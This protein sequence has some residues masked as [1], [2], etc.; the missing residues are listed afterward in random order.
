[1]TSFIILYTVFVL[2]LCLQC[3]CSYFSD[4]LLARRGR[5]ELGK[6]TKR[7]TTEEEGDGGREG[8]RKRTE[9]SPKKTLQ[10]QSKWC[11]NVDNCQVEHSYSTYLWI[12]L[13]F[14]VVF[15][16]SIW[17]QLTAGY[18]RMRIL[19]PFFCFTALLALAWSVSDAAHH[20]PKHFTE[21]FSI[22]E[23]TSPWTRET[24]PCPFWSPDSWTYWL[25]ILSLS[26]LLHF[27][28]FPKPILPGH[29]FYCD[30]IHE[31]SDHWLPESGVGPHVISS[32]AMIRSCM[33]MINRMWEMVHLV[34]I[35]LWGSCQLVVNWPDVNLSLNPPR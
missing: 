18:Q 3:Y 10:T 32:A 21:L 27:P 25:R 34:G 14:I 20:F 24:E 8:Q 13:H 2:I 30:V 1:M 19:Q 29:G 16:G 11:E 26:T 28:G 23:M 22:D 15:F 6:R 7:Q 5:G 31:H 35:P 4:W 33:P 17:S 9:L 12:L